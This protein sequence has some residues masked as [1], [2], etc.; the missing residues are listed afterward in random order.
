MSYL[1]E[2]PVDDGAAEIRVE[3]REPA[4]GLVRAARPGQVVARASR[5]LDDML[6]AVKPVAEA[7]VD[8]FRGLADTPDE[9]RVDFGVKLSAEADLVIASTA[10]EANFV[11]SLTW[12]RLSGTG[13]VDDTDS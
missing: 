1:V 9:I 2:L 4:D 8:R 10:T 3:L 11:V 7:F 13:D 12:K 6:A 5:S